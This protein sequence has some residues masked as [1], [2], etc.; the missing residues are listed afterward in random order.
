MDE[1]DGFGSGLQYIFP[2]PPGFNLGAL[3]C[4][5]MTCEPEETYVESEEAQNSSY[6]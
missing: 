5:Y 3:D 1:L 2:V 6:P 4:Q